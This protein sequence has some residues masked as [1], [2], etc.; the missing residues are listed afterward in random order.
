VAPRV[1]GALEGEEMEVLEF[2]GGTH[3][4]QDWSGLSNEKHRWWKHGSP[5]DKLVL[6]F[7][8]AEAGA[9]RVIARFL[10][11]GDYGIHKLSINDVP[12]ANPVDLYN[13]GVKV[14][15]EIDLGAFNLQAGSNTISAEIIGAN[16][17]AVK[18]YM[19]GLD[20]LR[21]EHAE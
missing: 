11:A 5:G 21:L 19:F 4:V 10:T 3:E 15:E 12:A 6:R 20:Y 18:S 13:R 7:Q 16:A 1:A 17:S 14:S 2:T 9:Y 8:V